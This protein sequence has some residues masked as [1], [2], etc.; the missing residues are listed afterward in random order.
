M[1]RVKKRFLRAVFAVTLAASVLP[2]ALAQTA[3]YNKVI[4]QAKTDLAAG[5]NPEAL[6]GSQKAIQMDASRWEAYLVA[7]SALQNQKQFDAAMDNYTKALE[8]S[9]ESKKAGVRNVLE[10]CVREKITAASSPAVSAPAASA[11][12]PSFD[13]TIAWLRTK[14][15]Q[16]GFSYSFVNDVHYK[17]KGVFDPENYTSRGSGT[18]GTQLVTPPERDYL[19]GFKCVIWVK[20]HLA[21]GAGDV[22]FVP[23][24][25][26]ISFADLP[27]GS[28][29]VERFD[30]ASYGWDNNEST[31]TVTP[32]A[33]YYAII[34]LRE[35]IYV[36]DQLVLDPRSAPPTTCPPSSEPYTANNEGFV[37]CMLTDAAR[38]DHSVPV[39]VFANH[40]LANRVAKAL[41]H[42]IDVCA[43]KPK[44]EGSGKPEVF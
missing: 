16:E 14:I 36:K 32:N 31:K 44:S 35:I 43:D 11:Q 4:A 34:G 29:S 2:M 3:D 38:S 42:A 12:S 26:G 21:E 40:D 13:E 10:Q 17:G 15:P 27:A 18:A 24:R 25:D 37:A 9:P 23:E 33:D 19:R 39:L 8:H 1:T 20:K 6:A 30:L 28:I 5:H 7:G 22:S 41:N